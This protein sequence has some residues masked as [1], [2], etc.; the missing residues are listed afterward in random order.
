MSLFLANTSS[1]AFGTVKIHGSK[2]ISN[3]VLVIK[4]L[5]ESNLDIYNLSNS[6]DTTSLAFYL[7]MINKCEISGIPMVVDIKN[8][9]TVARFLT[10]LLAFRDGSWLL[11][12][13]SRMKQRP[14]NGLVEALRKLGASIYYSGNHG[15]LPIK[16][17]GNDIRG[18]SIS[19]DVSQSSQFVSALMLIGPYLDE[20]LSLKF[21]G[22]PVSFPYIA[23]TK[24]LMQSFG[25]TVNLKSTGVDIKNGNYKFNSIT[26]TI[27]PDWSSASY[28]YETVALAKDA[29]IF[30]P[31]YL[32]N[33]I[34][35]DSA[36]AEI[37]ENFGV[38]TEFLKNG[39]KLTKTNKLTRYFS[40]DFEGCPDIVPAVMTTCAA[41]GINSKYI[42]IH[43]LAFKES[44]RI[45]ALSKELKKI[46]ATLS[47]E[48]NNYSLETYER[49]NKKITFD[50]HNDHRIAMCLAPLSLLFKGIEILNPDA[51]KKSYPEFW[52]DF[53][54]LNFASIKYM[55]NNKPSL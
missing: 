27:E 26:I 12:G 7:S 16:I 41:L 25:A 24:E 49:K 18:S 17:I 2:S 53:K 28:W 23:M 47:K 3:R 8:A 43:H 35:G 10:T 33:S 37:Y 51:V 6:D 32:K 45:D 50:T 19:V 34:Q 1:K 40:Y 39:I 55:T 20:G 30:L 54:K 5:S 31:G 36:L 11:T 29:E 52:D 13:C 38:N 22:K 21:I 14:I 9:G 48:N 4:E 15:F 46:G 44:N 42:N